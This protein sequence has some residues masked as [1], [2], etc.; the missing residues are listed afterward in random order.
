MSGI[1]WKITK[2]AKEQENMSHV[3]EKK[4]SIKANPWS[5]QMLPS[6]EK[7]IKNFNT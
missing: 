4:Y 7:N 1:M 2:H 5:A 3:E 6:A